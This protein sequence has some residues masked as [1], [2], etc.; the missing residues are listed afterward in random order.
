MIQPMF[1]LVYDIGEAEEIVS[2]LL[3]AGIGRKHISVLT[4]EPA[5]AKHLGMVQTTKAAE[6]G[7]VGAAIGGAVGLVAGIFVTAATGG[8]G[9]VAAGPLFVGLAGLGAGAAA[10]GMAGALVGSGIPEAEARY[11][12]REVTDRQAILIGV[13]IPDSDREIVQEI[14]GP[15]VRRRSILAGA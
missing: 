14:F 4:S 9:V 12:A 7:G 1:R 11:F 8:A 6:G 15:P 5:A 3:A 10:G 13:D 2:R